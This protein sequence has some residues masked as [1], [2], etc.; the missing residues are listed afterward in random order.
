[1]V[2]GSYFTLMIVSDDS[3]FKNNYNN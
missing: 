2:T 1:L 3:I